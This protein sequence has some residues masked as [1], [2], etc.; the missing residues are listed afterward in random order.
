[1]MPAGPGRRV[2]RLGAL[3]L[4][5]LATALPAL[6]QTNLLMNEKAVLEAC[7]RDH[8]DAGRC[9]CYLGVIK[10][11][12]G[13]EL[14]EQTVAF[15]AATFEGSRDAVDRVREA[16]D[17]TPE[18]ERQMAGRLRAAAEKAR[19]VCDLQPGTGQGGRGP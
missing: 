11:E 18:K 14:Y 16:F 12:A 6:A 9:R 13:P 5:A 19:T 7:I 8:A 4:A 2:W 15:V 17:L 1:M 10:D 3:C